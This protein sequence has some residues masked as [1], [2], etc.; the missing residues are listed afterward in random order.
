MNKPIIGG[1][2]PAFITPFSEN[3]KIIDSA[4]RELIDYHLESGL[5]AFYVG[6]STGEAMIMTPEQRMH[7]A[8]VV[9]SYVADR[10][11][12][13]IHVGAA[14]TETAV[15]LAKHA[16]KIGADGISSVPP[17]YYKM[18]KEYIKE[19]YKT[20]ASS[21]KLPFLIYN[22]PILTGVSINSEFMIEMMEVENIIGLKYTDTNLEEFRKI[23][24]YENGKIKAFMGYDA[25]LLSALV[26]GAD[27]GIGS[28]YNIMPRAF[29]GV[30][31]NYKAGN[32]EEAREIQWQIDRYIAIVKKYICPA[33][34]PAIKSILKEMGINCGTTKPP[35][36]PLK[37]TVV[38]DMLDDLRSNEFFE[39]VK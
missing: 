12:V 16:E 30:Y 10:V 21:I 35:I 9:V 6:G 18:S 33:N 3:G 4:A 39:F 26:M 1:V 32:F 14:D 8:E 7:I 22:I 13:I 17:Y 2:L 37:D 11:P 36:L 27:G 15:K 25:M 34:Q 24:A 20:I 29:A 23:K 31:D 19:F 5:D 38:R 28:F